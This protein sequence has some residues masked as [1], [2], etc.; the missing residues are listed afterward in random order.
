MNVRTILEDKIRVLQHNAD[1]ADA[2]MREA[3]ARKHELQAQLPVGEHA[4]SIIESKI[5]SRA[6]HGSLELAQSL[7]ADI[8]DHADRRVFTLIRLSAAPS[9]HCAR[10]RMVCLLFQRFADLSAIHSPHPTVLHSEIASSINTTCSSNG[11]R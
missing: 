11:C 7:L 6:A 9:L 10:L 5:S 8:P 4:D 1:Q 3:R 2:L